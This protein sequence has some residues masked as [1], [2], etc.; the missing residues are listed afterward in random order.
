[1]S[2][3]ASPASTT[4]GVGRTSLGVALQRRLAS[5]AKGTKPAAAIN[6]MNT[7]VIEE[8]SYLYL[9]EVLIKSGWFA[10]NARIVEMDG[11][12]TVWPH[13]GGIGWPPEPPEKWSIV[14]PGAKP[15]NVETQDDE[16]SSKE[17]SKPGKKPMHPLWKFEAAAFMHRFFKTK[18][19]WPSAGEIAEH[20]QIKCDGWEPNEKNLRELRRYLM[21]E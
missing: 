11:V 5:G 13:G 9:G 3:K 16:A 18:S 19:R 2:K 4:L 7:A 10:K 8:D 21:P 14:E 6:A 15:D 17:R 20:L 12:I 1:V